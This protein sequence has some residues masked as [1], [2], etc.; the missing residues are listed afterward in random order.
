MF[1]P[2]P[3]AMKT[4]TP[5]SDNNN[6]YP[7]TPTLPYHTRKKWLFIAK[8]SVHYTMEH[9]VLLGLFINTKPACKTDLFSNNICL[10]ATNLHLT[11]LYKQ[12]I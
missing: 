6:I 7:A 9:D 4:M 11:F 8:Q 12:P 3:I 10:P 2:S 5:T 1:T